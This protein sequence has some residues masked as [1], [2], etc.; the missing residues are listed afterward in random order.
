[1]FVTKRERPDECIV[2]M[3]MLYSSTGQVYYVRLLLNT[4]QTRTLKDFLTRHYQN[5][6]E[7]DETNSTNDSSGVEEVNGHRDNRVANTFQEACP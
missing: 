4:H 7:E 5:G 1:L 2:R 6:L 3:S